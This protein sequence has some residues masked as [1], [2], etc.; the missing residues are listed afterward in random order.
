MYSGK[1]ESSVIA[2]IEDLTCLV[3]ILKGKQ[4]EN[5]IEYIGFVKILF[6]VIRCKEI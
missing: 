1:C 3:W 6:P 2:L 5:N 4:K